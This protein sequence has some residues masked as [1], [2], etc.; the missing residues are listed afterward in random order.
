MALN[1]VSHLTEYVNLK[2]NVIDLQFD[3][4]RQPTLPFDPYSSDVSERRKI[5]HYLLLVAS[6]DES[7]VV[8]I[9]DNARALLVA[10]HS[11]LGEKLYIADDGMFR[12][13]LRGTHLSFAT[14]EGGNDSKHP[15]L[16]QR[17]LVGSS[18]R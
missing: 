1:V 14:R 15:R 8:G 4:V 16:S 17:V 18:W 9:A 5:A 12:E 6:V 2:S 11:I 7:N 3:P 13:G 10:L